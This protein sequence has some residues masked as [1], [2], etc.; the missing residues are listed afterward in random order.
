MGSEMCIRD[1]GYLWLGFEVVIPVAGVL[2]LIAHRPL[3]QDLQDAWL[4]RRPRR[5]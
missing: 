3:V 2:L 5:R 4:T 1:S